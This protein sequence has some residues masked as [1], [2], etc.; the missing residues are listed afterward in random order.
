MKNKMYYILM[1]VFSVCI[2]YTANAQYTTVAYDYQKNYFNEGRPLPAEVQLLFSGQS[3]KEVELVELELYN[4]KGNSLLFRN[5]WRAVEGNTFYIP[6]NYRLYP[7]ES[8]DIRISYYQQLSDNEKKEL[9]NQLRQ[10]MLAYVNASISRKG[11]KLELMEKPS[12]LYQ[13][14]NQSLEETFR[15]YQPLVELSADN[16]Q[17]SSAIEK[18]LDHLYNQQ[19]DSTTATQRLTELERQIETELAGIFDTDLAKLSDSR[20][21][22]NYETERKQRPLSINAGY[23][24]VYIDGNLDNFTYG[25]APFAGLAIPLGNNALAPKILGNASISLGAFFENF[26]DQN[27]DKVT[28]F[29]F[30]RPVYVGLDYKLFQFIRFNAGA[31]FLEVQQSTMGLDA[32]KNNLIIRPFIGLGARINLSVGLVK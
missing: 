5:T 27:G 4:E 2:A 25:T 22:D 13:Q 32:V 30:P 31:T 9:E 3:E 8:Y 19:V 15:K 24:G 1:L 18:K 26:E 10:Q 20:Y 7:S 28:G 23:G 14:L 16:M 17:L 12:K 11:K 21:I 6:V 29:I